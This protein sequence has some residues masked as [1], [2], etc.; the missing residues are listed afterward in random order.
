MCKD[1]KKITG[2]MI[3]MLPYVRDDDKWK[4]G[5]HIMCT[6]VEGFGVP[7]G[8]AYCL[9]MQGD[10]GKQNQIVTNDN[11]LIPGVNGRIVKD[12]LPYLYYHGCRGC[13]SVPLGGFDDPQELGILTINYVKNRRECEGVCVPNIIGNINDKPS[14]SIGFERKPFPQRN[15]TF[16]QL[17]GS[18]E[19]PPTAT[20]IDPTPLASAPTVM[21]IAE[22]IPKRDCGPRR[23]WRAHC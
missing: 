10:K 6:R 21:A 7:K 20:S 17:D 13:G 5:S 1:Q 2:Q 23:W 15:G 11:E 12:R 4:L 8:A 18:P 22:P 3:D 16:P 9:F 14:L 19:D